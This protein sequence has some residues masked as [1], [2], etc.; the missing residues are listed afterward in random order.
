MFFTYILYSEKFDRFYI[1]QTNDLVKRIL[2]HNNGHVH[3]TKAFKPWKIV[4]F[5]EFETRADSMNY[6][7]YLKNKKSKDFIINLIK[8]FFNP[9]I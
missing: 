6:E 3:S 5:K 4:Y 7:T 1:G 9:L 8:D 2:R